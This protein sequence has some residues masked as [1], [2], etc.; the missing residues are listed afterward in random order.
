MRVSKS[1]TVKEAIDTHSKALRI[2]LDPRWYATF[3]EIGGGQEVVRW[4]FRVG[5]AAG[6]VAKSMSAYEMKVRD[7]IYGHA[8]R[9]V[10]R[11]APQAR[12]ESA[13]DIDVE[14]QGEV[15]SAST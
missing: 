12:L 4:F 7:A 13:S 14:R 15:R 11:N 9:C 3:A 6:T 5:G 10:P 1:H 2:N 8:D